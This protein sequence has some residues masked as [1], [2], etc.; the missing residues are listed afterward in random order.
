MEVTDET[1]VKRGIGD[2]LIHLKLRYDDAERMKVKM[3]SE[4][5]EKMVKIQEIRNKEK[6]NV[7]K[8]FA[9]LKKKKKR[10]FHPMLRNLKRLRR[11]RMST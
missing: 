2:Y 5:L 8:S 4:E 1:Q 10:L 9:T 6:E 7:D 11:V 3:E